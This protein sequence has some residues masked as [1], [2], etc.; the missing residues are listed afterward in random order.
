MNLDSKLSYI[1]YVFSNICICT[2]ISPFFTVSVCLYFPLLCSVL[3]WILSLNLP[4]WL[5]WQTETIDLTEQGIRSDRSSRI[6]R[7]SNLDKSSSS[8][9]DSDGLPHVG[10]VCLL[11]SFS[12]SSPDFEFFTK[13]LN[14]WLSDDTTRW[15]LL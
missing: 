11:L 3:W 8:S 5:F 6:F 7:K 2:F 9:I 14:A 1:N 4:L 12:L 10:Q 13:R 15:T